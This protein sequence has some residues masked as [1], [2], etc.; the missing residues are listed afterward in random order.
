MPFGPSATPDEAY[1]RRWRVDLVGEPAA[2]KD[3]RT[4]PASLGA[5]RPAIIGR[6]R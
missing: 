1:E 6:S 4:A 2:V 3:Q 5:G